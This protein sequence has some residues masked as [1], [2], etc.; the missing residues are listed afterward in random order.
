M[1]GEKL[2]FLFKL[3]S[4]NK[5]LS[6]QVHPTKEHAE[7]LHKNN[8]N[9]YKD[10]NHKPEMAIAITKVSLLYGFR[11][12]W[13]QILIEYPEIPYTSNLQDLV[14]Y[15]LTGNTLNSVYNKILERTGFN[16]LTTTDELF[17]KLAEQHPNDTGALLALFMNVIVLNPGQGVSIGPNV[18]HAYLSGDLVECMACSDNVIRVGLTSKF[19]DINALLACVSYQTGLPKIH[20][21]SSYY[22]SG[23]SEFDVAHIVFDDPKRIYC[24]N[25]LIFAVV[26][27]RGFIDREG[28]EYILEPGT[29]YYVPQNTVF[30]IN[31][32]NQ[33]DIWMAGSP[34]GFSCV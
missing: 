8:P 3:L 21:P 7:Y 25:S 10:D 31:C 29:V 33:L 19:K 17:V 23:F 1:Q 4:V 14:D 6:I 30:D 32:T 28:F 15:L 13:H 27:G 16:P 18:P 12:D 26:Q 11:E 2:P 34:G 24:K 20:Q 22:T 9:A 5:S